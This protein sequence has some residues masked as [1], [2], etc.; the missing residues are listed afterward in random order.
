MYFNTTSALASNCETARLTSAPSWEEHF[1]HADARVARGLD[2]RDVI[3]QGGHLPLVQRQDAVLNVRRAHAV[4]GPHHADD[5][6]VDFRENVDRHAQGGAHP[7]Q[8]Q[9]NEQRRDG[10][11]VFEDETNE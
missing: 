7:Q 9:E 8:G 3:D 1:L 2:A 5:R 10:V 11:R 6:D 4:V